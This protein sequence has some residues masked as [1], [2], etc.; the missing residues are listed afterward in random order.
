MQ[1]TWSR[2]KSFLHFKQGISE[3]LSLDYSRL[4]NSA[5]KGTKRS[6]IYDSASL[7]M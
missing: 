4:A 6:F 3:L 7:E 1:I 2:L 5:A